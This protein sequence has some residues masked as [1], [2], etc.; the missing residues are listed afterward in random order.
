MISACEPP[1][2]QVA[3]LEQTPHSPLPLILGTP[4]F[5]PSSPVLQPILDQHWIQPA[6]PFPPISNTIFCGRAR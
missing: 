5:S 4:E 6:P 2:S 1:Q 3:P